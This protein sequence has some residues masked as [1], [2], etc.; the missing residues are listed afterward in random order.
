ML[1]MF[2]KSFI[3]IIF[4]IY[5]YSEIIKMFQAS[6]LGVPLPA[7]LGYMLR[8]SYFQELLSSY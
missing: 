2:P 8:I 5:W 4:L 6:Y 1:H 7:V 3:G